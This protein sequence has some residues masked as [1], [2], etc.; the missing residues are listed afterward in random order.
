MRRSRRTRRGRRRRIGVGEV[1]GEARGAEGEAVVGL[2]GGGEVVGGASRGLRMGKISERGW[3]LLRGADSGLRLFKTFFYPR[4]C[5]DIENAGC[6][7]ISASLRVVRL[8]REFV[9]LDGK[10]VTL[11]ARKIQDQVVVL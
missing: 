8:S 6:L 7:V 11:H 3:W 4:R 10:H 5:P 9:I 2:G 1:A